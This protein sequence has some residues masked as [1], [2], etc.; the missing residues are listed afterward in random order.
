MSGENYADNYYA[1]VED[2]SKFDGPDYCPDCRRYSS[3]CSCE[4]TVKLV[5]LQRDSRGNVL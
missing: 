2:T 4:E 3:K 5:G 1:T